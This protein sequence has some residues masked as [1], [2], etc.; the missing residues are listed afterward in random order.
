AVDQRRAPH[1][2]FRRPCAARRGA[3]RGGLANTRWG[4]GALVRG[5]RGR[6]SRRGSG[7]RG[8]DEAR[9]RIA[10]ESEGVLPLAKR[11]LVATIAA[12]SLSTLSLAQSLQNSDC[13]VCHDKVSEKTFAASVHGPLNCTDCHAGITAAP[14]EP[15]PGPVDCGTC[16]SDTVE[17]WNNS[18]H[19]RNAAGPR[20]ADCHGPAHE[21]LPSSDR[22][23]PT[24]RAA[25]PRTC[26][27]C[28]VQQ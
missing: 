22:K 20:C 17:G 27:R 4:S 10:A 9:H 16:H 2:R 24:Y 13:L 23:S 5:F 18:L 6:S 21:I 3:R 14:H 26:A 28:H 12:L 11:L 7:D 25:I 1:A 8:A 15:P 19:A